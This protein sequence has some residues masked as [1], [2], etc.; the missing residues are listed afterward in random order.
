MGRSYS[1]KDLNLLWGLSGGICAKC[2]VELIDDNCSVVLAHQAHVIAREAR[3][4]RSYVDMSLKDKDTY[5]NMLLL[6]PSCHVR[7]TDWS[8]EELY[9]LK[10]NHEKHVRDTLR[11]VFRP[12]EIGEGKFFTYP[13]LIYTKHEKPYNEDRGR[14]VI[15]VS[16]IASAIGL[17]IT[18]FK[19]YSNSDFSSPLMFT[20]F[21][22]AI[23]SIMLFS[24]K[25]KKPISSYS[26]KCTFVGCKGDVFIREAP[27]YINPRYPYIGQCN[28]DR[29]HTF[30]VSED[31]TRGNYERFDTIRITVNR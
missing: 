29:G 31:K 6:C 11:G 21:S 4:L 3:K 18:L 19:Y 13:Y 20:V 12:Y 30:T 9:E 5:M 27:N 15:T 24:H 16:I 22:I 1:R 14:K 7:T 8:K 26:A 17:G 23:L 28:H 2:K 25:L 10:F